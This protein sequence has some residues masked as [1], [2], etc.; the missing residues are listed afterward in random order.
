M[1]G[2]DFTP[3]VGVTL[4]NALRYVAAV[5]DAITRDL[6]KLPIEERG[7]IAG[8]LAGAL[9]LEATRIDKYRAAL[10]QQGQAIPVTADQQEQL[11]WMW[12]KVL[13]IPDS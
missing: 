5:G 8:L 1:K 11:K 6:T 7:F 10:I 2:N 4:E 13:G 3:A 12:R 9:H